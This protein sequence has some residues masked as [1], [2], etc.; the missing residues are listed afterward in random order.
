MEKNNSILDDDLDLLQLFDETIKVTIDER[1]IQPF[2][3][4]LYRED[5]ILNSNPIKIK[6]IYINDPQNINDLYVIIQ[7]IRKEIDQNTWGLYLF[8]NDKHSKKL[9]PVFLRTQNPK[10]YTDPNNEIIA[11]ITPENMNIQYMT[12]YVN[13]HYASF[14]SN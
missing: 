9:E 13:N 14:V 12:D 4:K 3:V 8:Y 5:S 1:K 2:R 10:W 11:I 6:D 7:N